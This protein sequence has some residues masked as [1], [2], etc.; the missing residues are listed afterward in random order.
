MH[1]TAGTFLLQGSEV[2]LARTKGEPSA[3]V[4][5]SGEHWEYFAGT[6]ES[7]G[8][9]G[10]GGGGAPVWVDHVD[11]AR[12]LFSWENK[13]GVVTM[14]YAAALRKHLM[15]VGTPTERSG[16]HS[17]SGTFDFYILESDEITGPWAMVSYLK[18]FGPQAYFVNLPSKFLAH[19]SE[20]GE[21]HG[22]G[23]VLEASLSYAFYLCSR[24][25]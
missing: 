18:E 4:M 16:V 6:R 9:G 23:A 14:T 17:M 10:G 7:G 13:T 11:G 5:G 25:A 21:G 22:E 19:A 2:Y 20:A 1:R 12:P 15:V 8:G 3:E 24:R